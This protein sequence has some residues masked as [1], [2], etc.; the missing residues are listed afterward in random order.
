MTPFRLISTASIVLAL[1]PNLVSAGAQKESLVGKKVMPKS[2]G[3]QIGY[4]DKDGKQV[5]V[6]KLTD[7]VYLVVEEQP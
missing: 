4:S 7:F 3:L 2:A 6:A 1:C 5:F